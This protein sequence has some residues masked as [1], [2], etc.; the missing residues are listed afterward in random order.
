M[1]V[2]L[3]APAAFKG[4]YG[5]RQIADALVTG[6]RKAVPNAKVLS[7]PVA[8][9]G[10]GLLEAVLPPGSLLERVSV[11]GPLGLPVAAELGWLDAETAIFASSSACG[12]PWF[13][14]INGTR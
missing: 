2:I 6:V 11:T 12:L 4:T 7:C 1:P 3:V 14:P 5:P 9:G 8:D 10:D 13:L